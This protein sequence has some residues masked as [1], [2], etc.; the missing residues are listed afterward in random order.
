MNLT[1]RTIGNFIV[2]VAVI[3]ISLAATASADDGRPP[4]P[5]IAYL[6]GSAGIGIAVLSSSDMQ[7]YIDDQLGV[8]YDLTNVG[9]DFAYSIRTGIRN[10]VQFEYR[11]ERG[12][13]H[14][15]FYDGGVANSAEI[16]MAIDSDEWLAK[17]NPFFALYDDPSVATFLMFGKGTAT[18]LDDFGQGFSGGDKN[19][20]GA[21][22]SKIYRYYMFSVSVEYH[23]ITFDRAVIDNVINETDTFDASYWIIQGSVSAGFGL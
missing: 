11:L 17:F 9:V 2:A 8:A 21:E 3:L 5:E 23:S 12:V 16:D 10:I 6:H 14:K 22:I 18:Y 7:N 4:Y 19:L 1:S 13:G 20:F 15:L